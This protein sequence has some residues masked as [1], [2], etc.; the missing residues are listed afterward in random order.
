MSLNSLVLK[1]IAKE[2]K[3][4]VKQVLAVIQ[5]LEDDN[6]VPFINYY[7]KDLTDNLAVTKIQRVATSYRDHKALSKR[8]DLILSRIKDS[9]KLTDSLKSDILSCHDKAKLEDLYFPFKPNG[10]S[11]TN[12]KR[13]IELL[14]LAKY[15]LKQVLDN[16]SS[17]NEFQKMLQ[18]QDSSLNAEQV[19]EEILSVLAKLISENPSIRRIVRQTTL[20]EGS[21]FTNLSQNKSTQRKKDNDLSE[22]SQPINK[23]S[24]SRLASIFKA[25]K[26]KI[27]QIKFE[28][29]DEIVF[30]KLRK[31]LVKNEKSELCVY[32]DKA[33]RIS[34]QTLLKSSI[35]KEVHD[36]LKERSD[37]AELRIV[38]S[39]L[40]NLLL[41]PR[42]LDVPIIGIEPS[43]KKDCRVVV[44]NKDGTYLEHFS[45]N[46][47]S[48][49]SQLKVEELKLFSLIQKYQVRVIGIASGV[50][51]READR[52]VKHF[53]KKYHSDLSFDHLEQKDAGKKSIDNVRDLVKGG[54]ETSDLPPTQN[55]NDIISG[56]ESSS[57]TGKIKSDNQNGENKDSKI[58]TLPAVLLDKMKQGKSKTIRKRILSLIV[59]KVGSKAYSRSKEARIEFTKLDLRTREAVFIGRRLQDPLAELVKIPLKDI[60]LSENQSSLDQSKLNYA[61]ETTFRSCVNFLGVNANHASPQ[62]L[63]YVSG[64]NNVLA[65]NLVNFRTMNGP[66][67][68]RNQLMS[69]PGFT[70][71]IFQQASGF[72]I[73]QNGPCPLDKTKVHP[74]SYGIV[75]KIAESL[76]LDLN[77][78]LGNRSK[79]NEIKLVDFSDNNC[80]I[81]SLK[82]I[83]L[84]LITAGTD[85]RTKFVLPNFRPELTSV[86]DLTEGT[87]LEGIITSVTAFGAFVDLGLQQDAL[88]HISELSSQ[89]LTHP[90]EVVHIGKLV[91]VKVLGIDRKTKRISL[92]LKAVQQRARAKR[93]EINKK[94]RFKESILKPSKLLSS[95]KE[96]PIEINKT[97]IRPDNQLV[98]KNVFSSEKKKKSKMG[99]RKP[100]KKSVRYVMPE[101]DYTPDISNL[102][103]SEKIEVLK[104]KFEGIR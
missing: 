73:I 57:E 56:I 44:I 103:F 90:T 8:K 30:G 32:L 42:V 91:K 64:L 11:L 53:F 65:D 35:Q 17:E 70:K 83:K 18:E 84:G 77:E 92:S 19:I 40:S 10:A 36:L 72:L 87:V 99:R 14:P 96:K 97:K 33:I 43:Q 21:I 15:I 24:L 37:T 102:S 62:M 67:T 95:K 98:S 51:A 45:T 26:E 7:R 49:K 12:S 82:A 2:S 3:I 61:L 86:S 50:G 34:Y 52:F 63:Q 74:E 85:P 4:P 59:N 28:V 27:L 41:S 75:Q 60:N 20:L 16:D 39:N 94:P 88:L 1:K 58:G 100:L 81:S 23:I 6:S 79:L 71:S 78:I 93:R 68:D 48:S 76:K 31:H 13:D 29:E 38:Q 54:S 66:F 25:E 46:L 89:F 47:N 22:F 69:V 104:K 5:L 55:G 80:G 9:D 101:V